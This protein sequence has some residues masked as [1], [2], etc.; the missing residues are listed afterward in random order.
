MATYLDSYYNSIRQETANVENAVLSD[1]LER[2]E[3]IKQLIKN[4]WLQGKRPDGDIIGI[5][6]DAEYAFFK[7]SIN[8][9]ADG[10]VDLTYNRDLVNN[11][12]FAMQSKAV[13]VFSHD[14]KF[15]H[16]STK[17]GLD[18]FNITDEETYKIMDEIA[19]K[20]IMDIFNKVWRI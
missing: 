15:D 10:N 16:I 9:L 1:L 2:K 12:D 13:E 4:R 6:K 3:E 5:Y 20:I 11:I 8:P 17:Y 18:N 19:S 7:H 14:W